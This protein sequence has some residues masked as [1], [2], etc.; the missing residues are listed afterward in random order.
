MRVYKQLL[1]VLRVAAIAGLAFGAMPVQAQILASAQ[2]DALVQ[3]QGKGQEKDKKPRKEK[4]P[5]K[6]EVKTQHIS[7]SKLSCIFQF[8]K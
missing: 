1:V 8:Q 3:A 4:P 5:R 7:S 2:A 6:S